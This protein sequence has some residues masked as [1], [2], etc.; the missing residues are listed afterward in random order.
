MQDVVQLV[1][2]LRVAPFDVAAAQVFAK[3][4]AGAAADMEA[5]DVMIAAIALS[6]RLTLVTKRVTA[7]SIF[8]GLRVENWFT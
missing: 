5:D 6:A 1:A 7:F 8:S 4:R 3:Y 2:S